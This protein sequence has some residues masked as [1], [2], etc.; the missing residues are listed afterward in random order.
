MMPHCEYRKCKKV[1][2]LKLGSK[3]G[4]GGEV[5]QA[6]LSATQ[7]SAI[8]SVLQALPDNLQLLS[9]PLDLKIERQGDNA[10]D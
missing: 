1:A 2:A 3:I 6:V 7:E 10:K 9:T 5:H 8:K 4:T